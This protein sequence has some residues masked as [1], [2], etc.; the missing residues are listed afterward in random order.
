MAGVLSKVANVAKAV[1]G[2][3]NERILRDIVPLVD[4][5]NELE[6]E[7]Q[8]KS[9]RELRGMTESFRDRLKDAK[10]F[11]AKQKILDQILPAAFATVREGA[12][13]VLITPAPESPYPM[14]RPFDVQLIGGIVLHRH[15]IAEMV[16][17]EG[18]TL[19]ATFAAYLNALPGDGVHIV[20]TNDY[21]ARRDC[22]WMTPVYRLLGMTTGAIQ[23]FQAPEEKRQAY[24]C[25]ITFGNNS[26]FGF[27]YLR[28]NMRYS[29][30]H[31]VQLVR[32]LNYAIVDEVDFILIDEARVPLILS[33][34]TLQQS[35]KYYMANNIAKSLRRD[36]DYEVKEKEQ[37]CHVTD[38]GEARAER[39]L[40]VDSIRSEGNDE[41][42][43]FIETALRAHE[44]FHRDTEYIVRDGEVVIVDEFTGRLMEGRVWSDGLHQ[45]V[46]VKE[47]LKLKQETQTEATITFQNFFR[48]YNKLAGMTG[49]AM[50]EAA[51]FQKIYG[52]GVV[53]IPTN[54]PLIRKNHPDR[55]FRSSKEKWD[56]V[57]EEI[58]QAHADGRPVL[59][60]TTSV[61][62]SEDLSKRLT[63]KGL[64][65]EVLNARPELA[66]READVVA[67]AGQP[68][69]ITIATNMAGRGTDIVLGPGVV[70]KGGLHIVGTARHEARRVDNQLRGRA[71]R[72]GDP[73]TS[74][75]Y[76]SFEDELMR[77]FAPESVQAWLQRAGMEEGVSI[78]SKMVTRWIERA[79]KRVEEFNF[80]IRKNLLEYDEVMDEQRKS[81]YAWRQKF[82]ESREVQ[83][84][85]LALIEDSI[86]DGIDL[87][88]APKAPRDEWD[89]DGLSEWFERR[90][91]IP[92]DLPEEARA[93]AE[94][95]ETHLTAAA[96]EAF[97]SKCEDV[98][99]EAMLDFGRSVALRTIDVKWKDHLHAMDELKSGIGLRGY[100]QLDPKI[101]YKS[102]GGEMFERMLI[103]IADEVCSLLFRVRVERR[104]DREVEG[105]WGMT[106][107]R[108]EQM[109]ALQYAQRQETVADA[110]GA[111]APAE[112]IRVSQKVGRNDPCP[113]G[114]GKKFKHCCGR[115]R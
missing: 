93:D 46:T 109:Q 81:V 89:L 102:E 59:V 49:T 85:L 99:V 75:F 5:I 73:G 50:T 107:M 43:H 88:V 94:V 44:F 68:G 105:I 17:G 18:K 91:G 25:D 35:E 53:A 19:V 84:E 104:T 1:I 97:L 78:E 7:F 4:R 11:E 47:G 115:F 21:L 51:E 33:G 29:P 15:M 57:A 22:E 71:G 110:A 41:W 6:P 60:G 27:D 52:L 37:S 72:Q 101:E 34:P 58:A 83:D 79:Q 38:E 108:R 30:E 80:D 31:Q 66:A 54:L 56:A 32:G 2:T 42:P 67:G 23:A 45:A 20:T 55:V 36:R 98:G 63:R 3:S 77:R 82:V 112:P 28:D 69:A 106:E 12:R 26:E 113:C 76:V 70:D 86:R 14:M 24:L 95:L 16:T 48:L 8:R 90:V 111:R 64:R 74:R 103:S 65:H 87:Y 114:S 100:A 96:R 9:D 13:R 40:G 92:A 39:M 10:G 61:E 62:T